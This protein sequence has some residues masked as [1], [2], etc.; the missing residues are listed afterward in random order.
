MKL[1]SFGI[2]SSGVAWQTVVF[3]QSDK[4]FRFMKR[5]SHPLLA[6][7]R[8]HMGECASL[9][10]DLA[11][12]AIILRDTRRFLPLK[13][14]IQSNNTSSMSS[15]RAFRP[16][17]FNRFLFVDCPLFFCSRSFSLCLHDSLIRFGST[18]NSLAAASLLLLSANSTALNL[19]PKSKDL[20]LSL[21]MLRRVSGVSFVTKSIPRVK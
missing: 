21:A 4:L 10:S 11:R 1:T 17:P 12:S 2:Q 19:K 8:T 18:S 3:R 7:K 20:C 14:I 6:L 9:H 15:Y 16:P 13:S 5:R